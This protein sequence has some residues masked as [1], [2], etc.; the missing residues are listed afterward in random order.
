MCHVCYYNNSDATFRLLMSGKINPNPGPVFASTAGMINCP[1]MNARSLKSCHKDSTTNWQ[2]VCNL[3][4]FQ[5]LVYAENTDVLCVNETL[6]NQNISNSEI[7]HSDFTIFWRDRSN[8]GGG[9]VLCNQN[10]LHPRRP[11]GSQSGAGEMA[12]RKFSRTFLKTFV[13]PFRPPLTD[14]PWVSEDKQPPSKLSKNLNLNR[15]PSCN[16]LTSFLPKLLR[17]WSK[18]FILVLL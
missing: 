3:H 16:S 8:R 11:R 5:G 13:A 7:L 12:R 6:L 17:Y 18:N 14:C 1:G 10:S 4:R 15:K 9:G 2:S